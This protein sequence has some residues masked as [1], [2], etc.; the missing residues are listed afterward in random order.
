MR[1]NL[2]QRE[3]KILQLWEEQQIYKALR[4]ARSG[5][6]KYVLHDGPPYANGQIHI[7]HAVNKVLKDIICKVQLMEGKDV[8]YVPG[9]DCHGLPIEVNVEKKHGKA[10]VKVDPTTFRRLCR[11][12]ASNEIAQQKA[13]FKRLGIIGD[14]DNPYTT[15][16]FKVEAETIRSLGAIIAKGNFRR[17]E[18][19]VH[20]CF[21]CRSA[22]AE[23][24]IEYKDKTSP[25]IDVAFSFCDQQAIKTKLGLSEMQSPVD[26]VIWTTTPWTIPS[27]RGLSIHPDF[28]YQAVAC[29]MANQPRLLLIA[30]DMHQSCMQRWGIDDWQA[31]GKALPGTTLERLSC[32]HPL[33][34]RTSLC[35][36]GDFVTQDAGT[37]IV[38]SSPAYGMDDFVIGKRYNLLVDNP[39][40]E[41]GVFADSLELFG[42]MHINKANPAIVAA[43]LEAGRLILHAEHEHSYPHCWRHKTPTIQRAT[44]Q[45]FID[46][47][48]GDLG[49]RTVKALG[50]VQWIPEWGQERMRGMVENRPDWCLSR[51]RSWGTPITIF[52]HRETGEP[53]P[54]SVEFI[55]TIAQ[56]IEQGGIEAWFA[57][58]P[59][60]LLGDD[61][62]AYIKASDTVDVWFD[63]GTTHQTVLQQ[64]EELHFPAN[65][66]LEG[67]DQ[68]RGWFQSSLLTS[69]CMHGTPPYQEVLTHGFTVDAQGRKMS[70]SLGNIIAPQ[71]IMNQWGADILRLWIASTDF[72]GEMTISRE[73]LARTADAYRRI[74]NTL[75]FLLGNTHDYNPATNAIAPSGMVAIDALMLQQTAR[76]QQEVIQ[77]YLRHN[78]AR[79]YQLIHNFCIVE[80]G[81]FYLDVLKDRLYT[82]A[83]N[84]HAR[85]S[86]QTVLHHM[87]HSLVR[88]IAP[89]LS[90]TA[91]EIWQQLTPTDS[92]KAAAT[93]IF[94]ATWLAQPEVTQCSLNTEDL[95]YILAV[96][97]ALNRCCE[98]Q[99]NQA[100]NSK[101]FGSL[102]DIE[103]TLYLEQNTLA[104]LSKIGSELRFALLC[105]AV[106]LKP[107][108]EA[109]DTALHDEEMTSFACTIATSEQQKCERCWHRT[110]SVGQ[111]VRHP[112]ICARCEE[113]LGAGETRQ[114][115]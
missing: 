76:L 106:Q 32:N 39:V 40:R 99:R 18:K 82:T 23:A 46:L 77:A 60:E 55:E 48:A 98:L 1:A 105:S 43:L 16:D 78:Y 28:L 58:A 65:M 92:S 12:Y 36:L 13:D 79:A 57:L 63:S 14:W 110:A 3:P 61:A 37:G 20:W 87:L 29:N 114:F 6:Q 62:A 9:W 103:A 69:M 104:S 26:I 30:K 108:A 5:Q 31:V 96:K 72:S 35:M 100:E 19:P 47:G 17:G 89:V 41:N 10:G 111:S 102:L 54:N 33:Y 24:E 90:F 4:S 52:Y 84:G 8:P 75:R 83:P 74:R 49:Q 113:N 27:N 86:A 45:W 50:G 81:A 51:Q 68:H 53:H 66:Y 15:M 71:E 80:L 91:E 44:T 42:G 93:S 56:K 59:E 64:R 107:L 70:K 94:L 2:A 112:T 95:R 97:N 7:G 85:R 21:D 67:S 34:N 109:P 73:I 88:L 101:A 38:H 25:A 115:V 22:L 11:E